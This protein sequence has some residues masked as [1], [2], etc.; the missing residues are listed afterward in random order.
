MMIQ[1]QNFSLAS[2]VVFGSDHGAMGPGRNLPFRGAKGTLFEGGIRTA[3][4]AKWPGRFPTGVV[5]DRVCLTMDFTHSLARLAGA[6]PLELARLDGRDVLRDLGQAQSPAPRDVFW[7]ARRGDRTWRAVRSGDWKFLQKYE[8]GQTEEW[9]F[10]LAADPAE[11]RDL[12][13]A[14]AARKAVLT[15]KLR[16]W[17]R[18]MDGD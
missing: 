14:D 16:A 13:Q 1:L 17:E 11:Q 7:P 15:E 2:L 5:S 6:R 12:A 3:M 9:L 18:G 4:M 10:N 8:G